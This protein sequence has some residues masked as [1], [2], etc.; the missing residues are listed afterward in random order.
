LISNSSDETITTT[1]KVK[2]IEI[3]PI[4]AVG[5]VCHRSLLGAT[6]HP[7]KLANRITKGVNND[8]SNKAPNATNIK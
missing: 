1:I 2:N 5:V 6:I 8:E 3:P 4:K 7:L